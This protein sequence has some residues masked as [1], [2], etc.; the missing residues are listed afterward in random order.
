MVPRV[1]IM[2]VRSISK[3][4]QP[5]VLWNNR[6]LAAQRMRYSGDGKTRQ[7]PHWNGSVPRS[8]TRSS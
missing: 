1:D 2:Q 5:F 3:G 4:S 8:R 7:R 6:Q